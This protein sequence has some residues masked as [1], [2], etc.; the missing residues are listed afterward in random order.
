MAN[1]AC[2]AEIGHGRAAVLRIAQLDSMVDAAMKQLAIRIGVVILAFVLHTKLAI[3]IARDGAIP[4]DV[5]AGHIADPSG[6][7]DDDSNRR[8]AQCLSVPPTQE[9]V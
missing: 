9:R 6:V 2:F 1:T 4:R 5:S 7:C 3:E 8:P